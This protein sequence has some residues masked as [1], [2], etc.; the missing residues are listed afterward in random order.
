MASADS[1]KKRTLV[2]SARSY[3]QTKHRAILYRDVADKAFAQKSKTEKQDTHFIEIELAAFFDQALH[4][5]EEYLSDAEL[6]SLFDR[7]LEHVAT[8]HPA[9]PASSS[10]GGAPE[11]LGR[12]KRRHEAESAESGIRAAPPCATKALSATGLTTATRMTCA[13]S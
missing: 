2:F 12:G 10:G 3:P 13:L 6:S 4:S 7:W 8:A 9:P 1:A 11:H 5:K